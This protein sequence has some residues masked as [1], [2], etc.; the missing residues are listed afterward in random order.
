MN[1]IAKFRRVMA[2][3]VLGLAP[4]CFAGSLTCEGVLGNSGEQGAALVRFAAEPARG[5]GVAYDRFGSL[6]DRGGAGVLNRYALDG[7]LLATYRIAKESGDS[8]QLALA[9][10]TLVLLLR[11]AL[12]TLGIASPAG[13]EAQPLKV[14]ADAISFHAH[15]TQLAARSKDEV[16]LF[17][18][19]TGAKQPVATVQGAGDLELGPDG[20]VYVATGDKLRKFVNGA[21]ITDGW[22][23]GRPGDRAQL[24]DGFWFGHAWHTTIKRFTAQMEPAP[25]VALGGSS[26]SFIGHL[27]QNAD[28]F[29]GRGLAKL[30]DDL[31][32]VSSVGGIPQL[33]E[34]QDDRQQFEIVRRIG[35]VPV[36][37][38]LGLDRA[39]NVW[40][41]A[42]TWRWDDR[43]DAPMR[44]GINT[45]EFPGIGQA[46]MLE[47]DTLVAPGSMWGKPTLVSGKLTKEV[48]AQRIEMPTSLPLK[49][50]CGSA[51]YRRENHLLLLVL[52]AAGKA[53]TFNL[54]N[55]GR[56]VS[57]AAP[58]EL[59]T[60]TP[61]NTWTALAMRDA[62]T[63][64]AAADGAVLEFEP[65]GSANW[66][67]TRRWNS[68]GAKV[69]EK[70]G[71]TISLAADAGRLWVTDRERQRVLCFDLT[72]GNPL[73]TFGTPDKSG[74]DLAALNAP[75]TIAAR[76]ERAVV[77][78]RGNQRL[79]KLR[80]KPQ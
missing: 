7:R 68:W 33:L 6:W 39:G 76:G 31:F 30:R 74:D 35:S 24:L 45:L 20:A 65:D 32:A 66:I 38:G 80:F 41:H 50:T 4:P 47:D 70:F 29:I 67:E 13:S 18:S 42:G 71:A 53:Q 51:V 34:W 43:P 63:L 3:A 21:E 40:H 58:V 28:L 10:D 60:V 56:Y 46:A 52:D 2:A 17:D 79:V 57:D 12:F 59:K 15:G 77:Y 36:C 5:M 55:D 64:L 49:E 16:F 62:G 9:G 11:G 22:P 19:A 78:D 8:D 26:G 48:S 69:E 73:A 23:K 54:S 44:L 14:G 37:R 1:G 72:T 27:D 25:G 61:V 75:E